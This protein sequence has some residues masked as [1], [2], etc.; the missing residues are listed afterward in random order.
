MQFPTYKHEIQKISEGLSLVAGCDEVGIG[1]LAGPVVAAA[2]ILDQATIGIKRSKHK[3]WY[4][5]RDSKTTN[6]KERA[7][8]VNFIR[9]HCLDFALGV[10]SH[11]TIDQINIFQA[12]RLAMKKSIEG[13]R[14]K[15]DFVFLDGGHRINELTVPQQAIIDGD[16]KV[17]SIAA[18]SILAKVSRDRILSQL[19]ALYPQYGFVKHKGYPTKL[20]KGAIIKHGI[21]PV[22]RKSFAFV[23][24]YV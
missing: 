7:G 11:E 1:P 22:H 3:W 19:D 13:L 8:L 6:E 14:L 21:S 15:P 5:V 4:R 12:G 16:V 2:V 23:Q 20:H 10:V 17:L 24:Q 18:A 9:D